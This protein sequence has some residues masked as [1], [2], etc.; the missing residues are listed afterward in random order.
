MRMLPLTVVL[1][2]NR[3]EAGMRQRDNVEPAPAL[4]EVRSTSS[5][6]RD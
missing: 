5:C 1:H 3:L 4:K 6:V 2:V